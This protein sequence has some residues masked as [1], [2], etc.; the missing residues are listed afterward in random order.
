MRVAAR[1]ILGH[2]KHV[3]PL[4][5]C[6]TAL[7]QSYE[8]QNKRTQINVTPYHN[9]SPPILQRARRPPYLYSLYSRSRVSA[10]PGSRVSGFPRFRVSPSTVYCLLSTVYC[11]LSTVYCLPPFLVWFSLHSTYSILSTVRSEFPGF[12]GFPVYRLPSTAFL[13][14]RKQRVSFSHRPA[15]TRRQNTVRPV[16]YR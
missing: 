16:R 13:I 2:K 12:R 3:R 6:Q 14:V 9:K 10:F 11:L 15:R 7:R 4:R 1:G 5:H 8:H